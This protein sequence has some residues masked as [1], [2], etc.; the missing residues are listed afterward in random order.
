[1]RYKVL[2][3]SVISS[4]KRCLRKP[5]DPADQT[6]TPSKQRGQHEEE[7]NSGKQKN[8]FRHLAMRW[9]VLVT[10]WTPR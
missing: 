10:G 5:A 1:M 4:S 3:F 7:E 6:E 8:F 9:W 2:A